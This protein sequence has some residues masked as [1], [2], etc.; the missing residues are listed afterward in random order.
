MTLVDLFGRVLCLSIYGSIAGAGVWLI[1]LLIDYARVP[2]GISLIL[3]GLAALR[4]MLPFS[5]ASAV[6][7]YQIGDLN[8]KIEQAL[9]FKSFTGGDAVDV[10]GEEGEEQDKNEI[11]KGRTV[12]EQFLRGCAVLWIAG[13]ILLQ[14]WGMVS[15]IGLKR[16]LRFAVKCGEGIYETDEI[17]SPCVAGFFPPKIYLT[18]EPAGKQREYIILHEKMHI[19][20]L[21]HIWKIFSYLAVSVHWFNPFCWLMW[22]KFQG[23]LEKACDERVLR[24]IGMEKKEDYGEALLNM[25]RKKSWKLSAPIGFGEEDT[26]ERIRKILRYQK[27]LLTVSVLMIVLGTAVYGIFFTMPGKKVFG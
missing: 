20:Y 26:G 12:R 5:A 21:D 19:R 1:G 16:K 22:K 9:D 23:E 7:V 18:A 4:L 27:P 8:I 24:K 10:I 17:A 6:S 15:Y 13:M 11:W 2:K 3:W 14:L 25:A